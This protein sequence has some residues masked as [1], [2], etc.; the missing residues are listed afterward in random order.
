MTVKRES[1]NVL[2]VDDD[3][4]FT[5]VAATFLEREDERFEVETVPGADE[6]LEWLADDEYQCVI[7]DYD[8]PGQNGIEFLE[9]VGE[10]DSDRRFIFYC[11]CCKSVP[12]R[13]HA[14]VS[15]H[16][17]AITTRREIPHSGVAKFSK[18]RQP[19]AHLRRPQSV[20]A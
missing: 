7:S 4:G 20:R 18:D 13:P 10:S 19:T 12:D 9:A 6:G 14:V 17:T 15:V 11:D 2:H 16:G 3:P 5:E 8:T 1:I